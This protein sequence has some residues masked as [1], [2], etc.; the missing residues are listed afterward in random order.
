MCKHEWTTIQDTDMVC[1]IGFHAFEMT[2]QTKGILDNAK[3]T[4]KEEE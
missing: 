4:T 2:S 1:I 3:T